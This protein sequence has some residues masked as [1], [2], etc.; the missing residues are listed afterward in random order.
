MP[1]KGPAPKRPVVNDPVYGAPI[2]T[3]LVNKIL[4]DGKKSLAE[5]IVYN[6]LAGVESKNSQDA[7]ATLICPDDGLRGS[8]PRNRLDGA[9]RPSRRRRDTAP[10]KEAYAYVVTRNDDRYVRQICLSHR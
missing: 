7:V 5:S 8:T 10:K 2:V 1:R 6:A 3:Q 4:V 9:R